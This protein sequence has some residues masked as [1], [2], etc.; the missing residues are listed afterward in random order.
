M[1]ERQ[2]S[3]TEQNF[4]YDWIEN[5]FQPVDLIIDLVRDD[6]PPG[7]LPPTDLDE[8]KYQSLRFWFTDNEEEFKSLWRDLYQSQD[9]ALRLGDDE[10]AGM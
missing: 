1:I 10:I 8:I 9:W 6:L 7:S 2:Y 5:W 3:I 4:A